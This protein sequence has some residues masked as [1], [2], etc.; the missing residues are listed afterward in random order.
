MSLATLTAIRGVLAGLYKSF[1]L[2]IKPSYSGT[3]SPFITKPS[4][5]LDFFWSLLIYLAIL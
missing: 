4:T 1:I 2:L 5:N 3:S